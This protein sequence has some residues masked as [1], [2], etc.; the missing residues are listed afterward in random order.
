MNTFAATQAQKE[1]KADE[2]AGAKVQQELTRL[3]QLK[4]QKA[5][6]QRQ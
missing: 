2:G 4:E 6:A 3:K 5:I 1:N